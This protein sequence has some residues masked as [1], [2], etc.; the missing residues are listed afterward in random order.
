[1]ARGRVRYAAQVSFL[2][3][4]ESTE[5]GV[6][7]LADIYRLKAGLSPYHHL[8][9]LTIG[10]SRLKRWIAPLLHDDGSGDHLAIVSGPYGAG[11]THALQVARLVAAR[12]GFATTTMSPDLGQSILAH[13]QRLVTSL[14][15]SMD[16]FDGRR[17]VGA[18]DLFSQLWE[19]QGGRQALLT[20]LREMACKSDPVASVA[21]EALGWAQHG[22]ATGDVEPVIEYFFG[23]RLSRKANYVGSREAAYGLLGMWHQLFRLRCGAKGLLI[24]LDEVEALFRPN[25]CP[26]IASRRAAYRAFAG[27]LGGQLDDVRALWAITPDGLQQLNAE[28]EWQLDMALGMQGI[29]RFENARGLLSRFQ[30]ASIHALPAPSREDLVALAKSIGAMHREVRGTRVR[31]E[32]IASEAGRLVTRGIDSPRAFARAIVSGLEGSWQQVSMNGEG[33]AL[34]LE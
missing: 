15:E 7:G 17:W 21:S 13:P 32:V 25:V 34:V 20:S 5:A 27:F 19:D 8:E 10:F 14:I 24:L 29:S 31:G 1:M 12:R 2:S 28:F 23:I 6:T 16:C 22:F 9:E 4:R 18:H 3:P 33:R 30:A 11:K 26:S